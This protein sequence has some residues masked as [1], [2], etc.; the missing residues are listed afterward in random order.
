MV[1]ADIIKMENGRKDLPKG[2][3]KNSNGRNGYRLHRSIE[4]KQYTFGSFQ[5]LEHAISVNDR[6]EVLLNMYRKTQQD[7][8]KLLDGTDKLLD[9]DTTQKI[10]QDQLKPTN[11]RIEYLEN[12]ILTLTRTVDILTTFIL[13]LK[14]QMEAQAIPEKKPFLERVW[15]SR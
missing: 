5:N 8:D 13:D 12:E 6:I 2:I 9:S 1:K 3:S 14:E 11:N 7:Y 10:L 15:G 4:G